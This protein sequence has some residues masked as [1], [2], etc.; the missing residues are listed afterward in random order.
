MQSASRAGRGWLVTAP[1]VGLPLS[2]LGHAL[3]YLGRYGAAGYAFESRGVHG[4]FPHLLGLSAGLLGA[5]VLAGLLLGGL[6]RL[7]LSRSIGL[8]PSAGQPVL[9]LFMAAA[10]LQLA[11][12]VL[13]ETLETAVQGLPLE[14]S[15]LL[16]M[17]AWGIAGQLPI[18]LLAAVGLAWLSIRFDAGLSRLRSLWQ[19]CRAILQAPPLVTSDPRPAPA[20]ALPPASVAPAVLPTR[21]PP[22]SFAL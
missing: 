18:A 5:A 6:G 20:P 16:P 13:Q 17:L 15:W 11:V 10:A 21:G 12:Y 19:A 2:E 14:F 7:A 3:V 9:A 8:R 4:Y 1:L 22:P